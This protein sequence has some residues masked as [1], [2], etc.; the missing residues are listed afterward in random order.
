VENN[1]KKQT[2]FAS[3]TS[4]LPIA[5]IAEQARFPERVI[6]MHYFSPVDKMPLLEIITTEK[7]ADWV[8][9]ACVDLGKR[10][11]KT[12]IVVGDGPGF[13]TT[14]ILGPYLNEAAFCLLEGASVEDIDEEL[15]RAGF[16]IGPLALLD[17]IGID[18]GTKVAETLMKALGPRL[19]P[20]D[21]LARLLQDG[22]LGKKNKKGIYDYQSKASGKRLA[23]ESVYSAL[24]L[25]VP[26]RNAAPSGLSEPGSVAERCLLVMVNEATH[27]LAD[28]VLKSPR[29]GD[30]GAIYGLGFPPYLGGPFHFVDAHSA[31][32]IVARLERLERTV[33]PRFAPSARLRQ[34]A[35]SGERF[36]SR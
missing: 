25:S 35:E 29:D 1:S 32:E 24:G 16:P 20:P 13:Y 30:I 17:E 23:D 10:Q 31:T 4:S 19:A 8:I 18:V 11:K 6:G 12:I 36:F 15:V 14:R 21:R 3:N 27:C 2:I 5:S 9:R 22:R 34:L 33:G 7:T 28:G 26:S